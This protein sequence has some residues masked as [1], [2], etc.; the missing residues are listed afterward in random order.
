MKCSL[1][2][3]AYLYADRLNADV[4][5]F[6]ADGSYNFVYCAYF[7]DD[8]GFVAVCGVFDVDDAVPFSRSAS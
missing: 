5:V 2:S 3:P 1:A 8:E 7:L 6:F 4:R